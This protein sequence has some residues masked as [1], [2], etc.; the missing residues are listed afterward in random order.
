MVRTFDQSSEWL[1]L[2]RAEY[3][4]MPGLHLTRAQMRRLWG[5]DEPTCDGVLRALTSTNFLRRSSRD[6]YILSDASLTT[7]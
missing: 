6:G 5:F 2:V 3:L 4:E 7:K 1:P